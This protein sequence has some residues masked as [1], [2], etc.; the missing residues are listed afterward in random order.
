MSHI[1]TMIIFSL[2]LIAVTAFWFYNIGLR[3]DIEVAVNKES[4]NA[5]IME[6]VSGTLEQ[7]AKEGIIRRNEKGDD[8]EFPTTVSYDEL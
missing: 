1:D 8:Y 6:G 4:Y 5:G 7:L 3:T 2:F